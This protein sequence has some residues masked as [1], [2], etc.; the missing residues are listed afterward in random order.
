MA[1]D[2][3]LIQRG[4]MAGIQANQP[5]TNLLSGVQTGQGFL[6]NQQ[7]L[8]R[9]DIQN[10][11]LQ[12]QA[13]LQ[14][15]QLEQ[16]VALNEQKLR[17]QQEV[18]NALG[19]PD[20]PTAKEV[21][22]N[23]AKVAQLPDIDVPAQLERIKANAQINNRTTDNIDELISAYQRDPVKGRQLLNASL[24][25]FQQTDLLSAPGGTLTAGEQEF[26]S[27]ISGFSEKDKVKARRIKTGLEPR[28]IGSSI[29][30][31]ADKNLA[32]KI[33]DTE[34]TIAERK[35]F[36]ELTGSSRSKAIDK[37]F[38][39]IQKIDK[40]IKNIDK[41]IAE[42]DNGAQTGA[43][44]SR[45]FPSFK[46]AT[47][48]LEQI[49]KELG[50]D[51]ISAVSFG[52]LSEEEL[53]LALKTALPTDLEPA[54]LR[55]DLVARKTAQTKLRAYYREQMDFL[56]SGGSISGFLRQK[57]RSGGGGNSG[58]GNTI[59]LPNGVVVGVKG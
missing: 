41:A 22:F 26:E 53:K 7:N 38:E 16:G 32:E 56:D 54:E 5:V 27:S 21:A 50:L 6:Q 57:E 28:A 18:V 11:I 20:V 45:F 31:I 24:Q 51:V 19:V 1:I 44:E 59:T 42:I 15:Q 34:A 43:I 29:Q 55:Q 14:Q 52:A 58:A 48:K 35:K 10:Q 3:N 25:A 30:T 2:A 39:S 33:G 49:Q 17:L 8:Q 13:P 9:G 37:G 46:A 23:I 40:N 4:I 47:I 36:G 12:Q